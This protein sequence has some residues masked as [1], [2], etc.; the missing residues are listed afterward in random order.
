M[1]ESMGRFLVSTSSQKAAQIDSAPPE[2]TFITELN[3]H[4][5]LFKKKKKLVTSFIYILL[6]NAAFAVT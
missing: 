3:L 1:F 5:K 2:F 4:L 6:C